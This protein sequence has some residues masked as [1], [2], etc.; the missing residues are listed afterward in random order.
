MISIAFCRET[1]RKETERKRTELGLDNVIVNKQENVTQEEVGEK[2]KKPDDTNR[3]VG[4]KP[5]KPEEKEK[6]TE[7]GKQAEKQAKIVEKKDDRE[8][9]RGKRDKQQTEREPKDAEKTADKEP[10]RDKQPLAGGSKAAKANNERVM[11]EIAAIESRLGKRRLKE[12]AEGRGKKKRSEKRAEEAAAAGGEN[13]RSKN[14]GG[15]MEEGEY[16][17]SDEEHATRPSGPSPAKRKE[18][19][20]GGGV[21]EV[22]DS[23]TKKQ[24]ERE[25]KKQRWKR[26]G[27]A[28]GPNPGKND[29]GKYGAHN[30]SSFSP[31]KRTRADA[32]MQ[33]SKGRGGGG[34]AWFWGGFLLLR[35]LT[36]FTYCSHQ[37]CGSESGSL[38]SVLCRACL[39][40][41]F[42]D[43]QS[44]R[45]LRITRILRDAVI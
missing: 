18:G 26:R 22:E 6:R 14:D 44:T 25:E 3:M 28:E 8:V 7:H 2:P 40:S 29:T 37:C 17:D 34:F 4:E 30:T 15:D 31:K 9:E 16:P 23:D 24:R 1:W 12:I 35:L 21:E 5:T 41:F 13:R 43:R 39:H 33:G 45:E 42:I 27:L 19:G 36:Y 32:C 10:E 38:G 11:Q 20:G